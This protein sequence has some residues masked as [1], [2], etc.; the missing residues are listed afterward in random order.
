MSY[1]R[2]I[3][4]DFSVLTSSKSEA[5]YLPIANTVKAMALPKY[6]FI[7]IMETYYQEEMR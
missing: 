7:T 5:S 4:G 1:S 6:A 3:I 2:S